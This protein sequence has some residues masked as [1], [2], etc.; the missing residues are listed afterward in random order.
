MDFLAFKGQKILLH[1]SRE[2]HS[3]AN[4]AAILPA[5]ETGFFASQSTVT[6]ENSQYVFWPKNFLNLGENGQSV[7][8][9]FDQ[10]VCYEV[11]NF[12]KCLLQ[13]RFI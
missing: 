9:T 11:L 12:A 7:M 8:G 4:I 10:K 1:F 6:K 3:R 5:I 13:L 2:F